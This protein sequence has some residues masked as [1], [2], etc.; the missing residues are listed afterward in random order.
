MGDNIWQK[1][2]VVLCLEL[3]SCGLAMALVPI[4]AMSVT[5]T[6]WRRDFS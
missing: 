3:G 4:L 1:A 6:L 2:K 5:R